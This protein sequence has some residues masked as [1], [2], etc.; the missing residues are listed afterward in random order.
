MN[1]LTK[2]P[3]SNILLFY[4]ILLIYGVFIIGGKK[5]RILY[6]KWSIYSSP[7]VLLLR[8]MASYNEYSPSWEPILFFVLI[9]IC[10]IVMFFIM[11][12]NKVNIIFQ[13]ISVVFLILTVVMYSIFI[14]ARIIVFNNLTIYLNICFFMIVPIL[15]YYFDFTKKNVIDKCDSK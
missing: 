10:H 12:K 2:Y 15:L 11:K 14:K 7:L 4:F 3:S 1:I 5:I 9:I 13:G 6:S 8:Y